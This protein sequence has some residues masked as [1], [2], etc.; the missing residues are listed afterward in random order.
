M[1]SHETLNPCTRK[2]DVA[3]KTKATYITNIYN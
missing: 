2:K 1:A 3:R